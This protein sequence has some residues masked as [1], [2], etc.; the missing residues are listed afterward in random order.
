MW[1]IILWTIEYFRRCNV[2]YFIFV[3]RYGIVLYMCAV[4]ITNQAQPNIQSQPKPQVRVFYVFKNWMN[5]D[6]KIMPDTAPNDL[7]ALTSLFTA[8][9]CVWMVFWNICSFFCVW[10][11]F[12]N[13]C[14]FF[15]V[16]LQFFFCLWMITQIKSLITWNI[17]FFCVAVILNFYCWRILISKIKNYLYIYI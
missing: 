14:S 3:L 5:V 12:W 13:I 9:F 7:I 15:C 2:S 6:C 16:C 17:T 8:I 1:F 11:V 10:M 4:L